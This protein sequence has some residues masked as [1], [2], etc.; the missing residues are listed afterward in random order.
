MLNV[1]LTVDTEIWPFSTGW[2]TVPLAS[3]HSDFT[4]EVGFY[5]H[6]NTGRGSFG[7]PFQ[8]ACLKEHGLHAT[9]FVESLFAGVAGLKPLKEIVSLIQDQGQEVQLHAH[10]EW[11]GEIRDPALPS[12]FRQYIRQFS[13]AEQTAIIRRAAA[14]LREAGAINVCAFRAGSFGANFDTLRALAAQDIRF[15]SSHNTCL[16]NAECGLD[17]G[18]LLTQPQLMEGVYEFPMSYFRDYPGHYR[19]AQ[20]CACSFGEMTEALLGAWRA[21]WHAFVIL[22]HGSELLGERKSFSKPAAPN[23]I[24]VRRFRKLCGFLANNTDKFRTAVFSEIEPAT[25]PQQRALPPLESAVHRTAW[26]VAEQLA[27]R[28]L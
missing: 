12:H 1:F 14:N 6:G 2:P 4:A 15:D 13:E 9:Y 17:T 11:L 22:L 18:Y 23:T 19:H 3:T 5:I 21:G 27:G 25:I 10:T 7:V 20:L 8:L 16:L 26:R 24:I 28:F